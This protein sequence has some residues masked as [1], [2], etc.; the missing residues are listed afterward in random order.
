[1]A[2]H[3]GKQ[4]LTEYL[5]Y[6]GIFLVSFFI[7]GLTMYDFDSFLAILA[8]SGLVISALFLVSGAINQ[9]IKMTGLLL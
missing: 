1:M 2:K 4:K 8:Y 7:T 6:V 5:L 9:F 3:A